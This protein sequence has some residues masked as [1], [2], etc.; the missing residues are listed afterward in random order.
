MARIPKIDGFI[1]TFIQ[2]LILKFL[3]GMQNLNDFR[4]IMYFAHS[5]ISAFYYPG[6][7]HQTFLHFPFCCQ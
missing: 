5:N 6:Q 1:H 2:K 4:Q 7:S 3:M